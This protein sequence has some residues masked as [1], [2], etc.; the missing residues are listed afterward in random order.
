MNVKDGLLAIRARLIENDAHLESVEAVDGILKRASLPA[1]QSATA[2]SLLQ[3]V[4]MLMRLPVSNANPQVYN[5]F[6]RL[7]SELEV[8]ADQARAERAAEDAKP[9]PKTKKYYKDLKEKGRT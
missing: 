2:G 5:D 1:A 6:V 4:R 7:E 9:V 3:M 8:R